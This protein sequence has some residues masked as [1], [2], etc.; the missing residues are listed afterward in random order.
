MGRWE[1]LDGGWAL[2]DTGQLKFLSILTTDMAM[3][4][5]VRK[6]QPASPPLEEGRSQSLIHSRS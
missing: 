2:R 4:P 6:R 5:H 1:V 3:Q